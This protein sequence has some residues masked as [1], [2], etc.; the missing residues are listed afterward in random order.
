MTPLRKYY[1][2]L[3]IYDSHLNALESQYQFFK[4]IGLHEDMK[5]VHLLKN[6]VKVCRNNFITVSQ[7][8]HELSGG[9][10]SS[11]VCP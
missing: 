8:I 6:Q 1:D 9:N 10:D 2:Q 5:K 11:L 7:R 4:Q 3:R